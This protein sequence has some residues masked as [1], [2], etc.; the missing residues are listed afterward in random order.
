MTISSNLKTFFFSFIEI[1]LS[2][3]VSRANLYLHDME[4]SGT[5]IYHVVWFIQVFD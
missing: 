2:L 3:D 5:K 1:T 4:S